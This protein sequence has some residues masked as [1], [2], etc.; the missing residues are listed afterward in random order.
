MIAVLYC[1]RRRGELPLGHGERRLVGA[2]AAQAA[3]ALE[4]SLLLANLRRQVEEHRLFEDYL[5]RIF[6]F[7]AAALLI[8]DASGRVLRT[9]ERAAHLLGW[10]P[11]LLTG[12]FLFDFVD[13]R[14]EWR[15]Y[16]PSGLASVQIH[17][18]V[19]GVERTGLLSTST[20]EVE[21]G[22]FDGRVVALD[23]ITDRSTLSSASPSRSA[24]PLSVDWP[25]V[26][27]T[28]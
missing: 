21:P 22:R 15:S 5:E 14:P 18:I 28:R 24:S 23:D 13:L 25:P 8:C 1:G 11:E 7:S 4:N 6:Q 19:N 26:S 2:L 27:R 16:L 17:F 20:L 3:L 9:N 12:R 10:P